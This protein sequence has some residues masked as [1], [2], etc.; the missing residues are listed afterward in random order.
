MGRERTV[1]VQK[2]EPG[3][4]GLSQVFRDELGVSQAAQGEGQL[5]QTDAQTGGKH[6]PLCAPSDNWDNGCERSWCP[7]RKRPAPQTLR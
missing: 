7:K 4:A 3:E 5:I 2:W 1:G 6:V